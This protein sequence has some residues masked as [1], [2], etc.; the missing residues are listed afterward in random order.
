M[1]IQVNDGVVQFATHIIATDNPELLNFL[2]IEP[3]GVVCYS[4]EE[5]IRAEST[6]TELKIPFTTETTTFRQ[7][8]KDKVM[9]KKY[10][11]RTEAIKHLNDE[12]EMPKSEVIPFLRR[13]KKLLK[14]RLDAVVIENDSLKSRLVTVETEKEVLKS[15]IDKVEKEKSPNLRLAELESKLA[16]MEVAMANKA[17]KKTT[18]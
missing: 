4:E 15:R 3:E 13:E 7:D 1:K 2:Q 14:E 9:G 18:I 17:D 5:R 16:A 6:L 8:H 10:G 12:I 11:S